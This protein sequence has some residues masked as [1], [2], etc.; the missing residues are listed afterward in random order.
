ML[1]YFRCLQG[2]IEHYQEFRPELLTENP[3]AVHWIDLEDPS[4]QESTILE[5]PFRFHPL[6]IQPGT[7]S[8][9]PLTSTSAFP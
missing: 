2:R 8:R 5:D 3:E 1:S 7:H 4:V 6:A 9:M